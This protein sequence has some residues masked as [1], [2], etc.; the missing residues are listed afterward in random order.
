MI[1]FNRSAPG[2]ARSRFALMI[3]A[4]WFPVV[5]LAV[6]LPSTQLVPV[7]PGTPETRSTPFIAWSKDLAEVGYVEEEFLV[8]GGANIYEYSSPPSAAVQVRDADVP[9]TSRILVRRPLDVKRFNGTVYLEILNPTAGWDG[10]PTYQMT[11][12]YQ[13]REGA[14]YV[15]LTSKP[16]A[17]NF[18]RD[19]WGSIPG[20]AERNNDRYASLSM[21]L[22]G[23]VWDMIS[24]V[25]ALVKTAGHASNPLAGYAVE[26]IVLLGYSQSVAYQ[27]TY[28]NSF[29]ADA[30]MPDGSP[31]IDAYFVA[32]GGARAKNVNR[33]DPSLESLPAGDPRNKIH[34]DAPVIRFQTQTEVIGFGSFAVRQTEADSPLIR[35]YEMAGG[36]HVDVATNDTGGLALARDLGLPNFGAFCNLAINPIRIGFVES[37][38]LDILA[39]WMVHDV[40]PPPSQLIELTAG[41]GGVPETVVDADGNAVG[42]VRPPRLEVPLGTYLPNNTGGGFCFLFGGYVPFD[43]AELAA[44]YRNHGQHQRQLTQAVSTAVA[45]RFLLPEDAHTLR[46]ENAKSGIGK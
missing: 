42:G 35:M 33:P 14:A 28:A 1:R 32:A 44:R 26:R 31:V 22:F 24:E 10:D 25:G 46:T 41:G 12:E 8:S 40:Q 6:D 38:L 16:V 23:Q 2:M 45:D 27:V 4:I 21:P 5:A 11:H 15:G 19:L 13:I 43:D 18:L 39:D 7:V 36:A 29:H 30:T 17:L 20:F 37:A 3:F 9:Y 34:V